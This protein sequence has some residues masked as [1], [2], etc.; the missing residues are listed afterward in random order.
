MSDHFQGRRFT[1]LAAALISGGTLLNLLPCLGRGLPGGDDLNVHLSYLQAIIDN[2]KHGD[3]YPYWLTAMNKGAGS[4]AF[5]IQ[6]PLPYALLLLLYLSLRGVTKAAPFDV[7][8]IPMSIMA[9]ALLLAMSG[10]SSYLWLRTFS[11]RGASLAG[12]LVFLSAPYHFLDVYRR[13]ALGEMAAFAVLPLVFLFA[14]RLAVENRPRDFVALAISIALLIGCHPITML[15]AAPL[16]LMETLLRARP[17]F[18]FTRV[19]KLGAAAL[20]GAL[21][22]SFYLGSVIA[23]YKEINK[24]TIRDRGW[25]Y[26]K[27]FLFIPDF[28]FQ[29]GE[30]AIQARLPLGGALH[31][32]LT[33]AR[34]LLAAQRELPSGTLLVALFSL[35]ITIAGA[36]LCILARPGLVRSSTALSWM[37]VGVAS[38][39]LQFRGSGWISDAVPAMKAIQ[40]PWR[41]SLITAMTLTVLT[42]CAWD[43]LR[44]RKSHRAVPA[45]PLFAAGM[46]LVIGAGD[47]IIAHKLTHFRQHLNLPAI[48]L[49][50]PG[51]TGRSLSDLVARVELPPLAL[52]NPEAFSGPWAVEEIHPREF[53]VR[54]R[55]DQ[56]ATVTFNLVCFPG[57]EAWD[58]T[59]GS[60]VP[61]SCDPSTGLRSIALPRGERVLRIHLQL[62]AA[63]YLGPAV[64]V[65]T[66]FGLCWFLLSQRETHP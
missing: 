33:P 13:W 5:F 24:Y 46:F 61:L 8:A 9:M 29:K 43:R 27:H 35:M 63:E 15:L 21:L 40:F 12:A 53:H 37:L 4:P 49:L 62:S 52:V 16:V 42:A 18:R 7:I 64:S 26:E 23:H 2:L 6:Y 10:W 48:D 57:W 20:A 39:F 32:A 31:V 22:C 30:A 47:W 65:L 36:S 11:S 34:A 1:A 66:V 51:Y 3:G 25:G 17:E 59:A 14:S 44:Q 19:A 38:V 60:E 55:T 56:A 54:T 58:E 45:I 28:M 50:Y 41:F